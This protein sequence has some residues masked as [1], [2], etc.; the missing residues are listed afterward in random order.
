MR[1]PV[2]RTARILIA[3]LSFFLFL[4][5][6]WFVKG[7]EGFYAGQIGSDLLKLAAGRFTVGVLV[8]AAVIVVLTLLFGR[9]YCSV[10]CP[11]GILQDFMMVFKRKF[12][13]QKSYRVLRYSVF[14][15]VIAALAGGFILPLALLMPSSNFLMIE[16][17]IFRRIWQMVSNLLELD[18]PNQALN[19]AFS[20]YL[21]AWAVFL[22]LLVL[23]RW[24]GRIYCNTLCPVGA[25]LGL[26]SRKARYKVTLTDAC[27]SCGACERAC[28]SGCIDA[29]NRT[30]NNENC[31]M[32]LNC[33]DKCKFN[34]LKFIPAGKKQVLSASRRDFLITGGAVAGGLAA[35]L[36]VSKLGGKLG[37]GEVP[38]V[39]PPGAG[40]YEEFQRKC[41]SCGLCIGAC[42]GHVLTHSAL[43]YGIGGILQPYLNFKRGAC[44]F[45]CTSCMDVC[46]CGALEKIPLPE[47]KRLRLGLVHY[48][49]SVCIPFV[50]GTDCGACSEHCPVGALEMVPYKETKIPHVHENLCIGC[51]ACQNICPVTPTPAVVVHGVAKQFLVEKPKQTAPVKLKAEEDFPF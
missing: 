35:G 18:V 8:A 46:P 26:L 20:G 42:K 6:T 28:K 44:E 38:P 40:S 17:N 34:A 24:R 45:N 22:L 7:Y 3:A 12:G 36:A 5:A 16:N 13:Q 30:V 49:S 29:K 23:T 1:V 39:M 10:I 48:N 15:C 41:V 33:L 43:Q 25:L 4:S 9:F 51:G 2:Y 11:L 14:G 37:G 19:P 50:D 21:A 27:V 32:C 47:K 31:V